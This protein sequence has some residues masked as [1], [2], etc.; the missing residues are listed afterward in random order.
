MLTSEIEKIVDVV[1][2]LQKSMDR[3]ISYLNDNSSVEE[4]KAAAIE[5]SVSNGEARSKLLELVQKELDK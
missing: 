4:L 3:A 2:L 1:E 5:L